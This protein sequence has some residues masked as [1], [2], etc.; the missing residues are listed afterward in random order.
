MLSLRTHSLALHKTFDPFL[1]FNKILRKIS[2]QQR[3]TFYESV[4]ANNII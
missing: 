3:Y 1:G 2:N 4:T